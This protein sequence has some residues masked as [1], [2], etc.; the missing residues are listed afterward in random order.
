MEIIK[1]EITVTYFKKLVDYRRN[2]DKI[3]LDE[4]SSTKWFCNGVEYRLLCKVGFE[5]TNLNIPKFIYNLFKIDESKF[6]SA[7]MWHNFIYSKKGKIYNFITLKD[8]Y[9]NRQHAD[10]LLYSH[11]IK[12]GVETKL[13]KRIYTL[14]RLFG[15]FYWKDTSSNWFKR[16]FL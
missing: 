16:L 10:R 5:W 15:R 6:I 12:F 1:R 3:I 8:D 14:V 7:V 9:I 4:N 2:G 11:L 13:A